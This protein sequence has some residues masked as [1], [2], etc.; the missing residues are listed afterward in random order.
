[1][2]LAKIGEALML[3]VGMAWQVGWSLIL[4]FALS[5]LVLE[6]GI[7]LWLLMGWQFTAAEWM[8][9]WCSSRS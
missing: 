6:L 8:A 2:L 3:S 1:V 9:G 7:I 5:N 4:G